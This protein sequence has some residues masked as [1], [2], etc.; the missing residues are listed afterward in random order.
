MYTKYPKR[1]NHVFTLGNIGVGKSSVL[2]SMCR[3]VDRSPIAQLNFYPEASEEG[4]RFLRVNW[5]DRFTNKNFPIRSRPG[6]FYQI[7]V[8]FHLMKPNVELKL[9]FQEIAGEDL[10]L[11]DKPILEN[12]REVEIQRQIHTYLK[13]CNVIFMVTTP[14]SY[15]R[16]DPFFS[17]F[18]T[19]LKS[20]RVKKPIGLIIN[21]CDTI[22]ESV[23][24]V[25][26]HLFANMPSTAKRIKELSGIVPTQ[27]FFYSTAIPKPGNK[28]GDI[29]EYRYPEYAPQI[30]NWL[31]NTLLL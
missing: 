5:L 8:G 27:V 23:S 21:K 29:L 30:L 25:E 17:Y 2:G 13:A 6:D 28:D 11:F 12:E 9:T 22:G 20:M 7:R 18:F 16:D 10:L 14:D 1:S 4:Y 24:D 15:T 3:Y 26:K 19:R 31:F